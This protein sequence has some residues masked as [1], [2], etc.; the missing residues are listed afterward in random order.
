MIFNASAYTAV[1]EAETEAGSEKARRINADA[2]RVMAEEA[3]KLESLFVHFST[4]YVFD[5]KKDFPYVEDDLANPLNVYGRSK[6]EG[7]K[8][9]EAVGGQYFIFRTSWVYTRR[10]G[11]FV[12]KVLQWARVQK[13]LKIVDD[14]VGSP[15]WSA[16]LAETS[17]QACLVALLHGREWIL[18]NRGI[19]HLGGRGMCTR[20]EWAEAI[21]SLD[22]DKGEQIVEK[23]LAAKTEDY[24][25]PAQ[26]PLNSALDCSKFE[27]TF[28]LH[29]QEW[30][31]ALKL[32][33]MSSPA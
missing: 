7:E 30:M 12:G 33:L 26:R 14:Q 17:S 19:Y 1:D 13:E 10:P 22:P 20:K 6:L 11:S 28:G 31:S 15:T 32:C 21:I 2:C 8:A 29:L 27:R 24:R 9:I 18:E 23:I 5:G 4:D 3:K 16:A 25:T